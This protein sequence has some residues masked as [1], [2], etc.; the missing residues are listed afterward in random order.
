MGAANNG[1][2]VD[3]VIAM[4]QENKMKVMND[5]A[6]EKKEMEEYAQF[7][8]D[9]TDEKTYAIKDAKRKIQDLQATIDDAAAQVKSF[10]DEI[11]ELGTEIAGKEDQLTKAQDVRHAEHTDFAST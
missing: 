8:D 1:S 10:E 7:C 4:L 11:A 3:K 9:E 6:S 2:P 5:L